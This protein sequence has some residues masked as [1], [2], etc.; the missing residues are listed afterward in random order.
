[1]KWPW[2]WWM[3]AR[4]WSKA[5]AKCP[6]AE[7]SNFTAPPCSAS[8]TLCSWNKHASCVSGSSCCPS[9]LKALLTRGLQGLWRAVV[10]PMLRPTVLCRG[11]K[12]R[13]SCVRAACLQNPE[14]PERVKAIATPEDVSALCT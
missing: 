10:F 14:N 9:A 13:A 1:M 2:F 5:R 8:I 3:A 7:A 4:V 12:V 11:T 6:Q